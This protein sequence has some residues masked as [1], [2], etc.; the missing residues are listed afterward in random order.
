MSFT[1]IQPTCSQ[2]PGLLKVIATKTFADNPFWYIDHCYS[3]SAM[4]ISESTKKNTSLSVD[5]TLTGALKVRARRRATIKFL[6]GRDGYEGILEGV[7]N[8]C[9]R[10]IQIMWLRRQTHPTGLPRF[11]ALMRTLF[12]P[13][14]T[15]TDENEKTTHLIAAEFAALLQVLGHRYTHNKN[16]RAK[17]LYLSEEEFQKLPASMS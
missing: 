11:Q 17:Y 3:S 5:L 12:S 4:S 6:R 7:Y 1:P 15:G 8:F 13:L 2:D 14:L 9:Y 16:L 10:Y